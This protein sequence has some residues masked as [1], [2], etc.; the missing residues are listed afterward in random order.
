MNSDRQ[1]LK[2][3]QRRLCAVIGESMADAIV[4]ESRGAKQT[5]NELRVE[6]ATLGKELENIDHMLALRL[7]TPTPASPTQ[8][9]KSEDPIHVA[10]ESTLPTLDP[11][12]EAKALCMLV[13]QGLSQQGRIDYA[14]LANRIANFEWSGAAKLEAK[15]LV[16]ALREKEKV[17]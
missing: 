16:K 17:T 5:A 11:R 14:R 3:M 4:A 6:C 13:L 9:V 12:P 10:L 7:G 8:A 2:A 15:L 1:V